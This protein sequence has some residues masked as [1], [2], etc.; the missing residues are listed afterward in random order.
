MK[1]LVSEI[2]KASS[3]Q[4]KLSTYTIN[5]HPIIYHY[6]ITLGGFL[7]YLMGTQEGLR[8]NNKNI[9]L[10]GFFKTFSEIRKE[11]KLS[12]G[13]IAKHIKQL[14]SDNFVIT[15]VGG[16]QNANYYFVNMEYIIE[17]FYDDETVVQLKNDPFIVEGFPP[18][19]FK[20]N[21]ELN[22]SQNITTPHSKNGITSDQ[23]WTNDPQVGPNLDQPSVQISTNHQSIIGPTYYKDTN[24]IKKLDYNSSSLHS[25]EYN[26][27][28]KENIKRK[29]EDP[30][31]KFN[32]KL[33]R[34][35][36]TEII[37][38]KPKDI[39]NISENKINKSENINNIKTKK[40][41]PKVFIKEPETALDEFKKHLKPEHIESQD[42]TEALYNWSE[43]RIFSPKFKNNILTAHSIKLQAIWLAKLSVQ[44][45]LEW[46]QKAII[47]SWQGIKQQDFNQFNNAP[48][49]T[50]QRPQPKQFKTA[51]CTPDE[52]EGIEYTRRLMDEKSNVPFTVQDYPKALD[53]LRDV[54][55][56]Q[57]FTLKGQPNYHI[58]SC[59]SLLALYY[60]WIRDN[61]TA[62]DSISIN[63]IN[64][65]SRTW[66]EFVSYVVENTGIRLTTPQAVYDR[67][68]K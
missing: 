24:T 17:F 8:K 34:A 11:T 68:K 40:E 49:Q 36:I 14:I 57:K 66:Y 32:I 52:L 26:K 20:I 42:Y 47:G 58:G 4:K 2:V 38:N 63:A 54:F 19:F 3:N 41:R 53:F 64:T 27:Q 22:K 65:T 45:G 21:K 10:T 30:N 60:T 1:N 13:T 44:E 51:D 7:C 9:T 33:K 48:Y 67:N 39:N 35:N 6:G 56:I 43:V 37:N 61:K 12:K 62:W 23:I 31:Y 46:I 29:I 55:D 50:M 5:L 18:V 16:K 59:L 28:Y 15:T 25:E